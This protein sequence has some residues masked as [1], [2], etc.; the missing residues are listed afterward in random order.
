MSF[1]WS[2][3][4]PHDQAV[5]C[6]LRN[7]TT[8][9]I[10]LIEKKRGLGAGKVNAPGGKLEEGESFRAAAI[11]ETQEEVGMIPLDPEHYGTLRFAFTDGYNLEVGVF[12][13]TRWEGAPTETDEA[14]PFW[15]S[16]ADI[17]FERMWEDDAHWLPQVLAGRFVEAEMTF[18]GDVMVQWYI[19]FSHGVELIGTARHVFK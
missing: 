13:A 16:E 9:E 19:R 5:L 11:R 14:L 8:D 6:F 4:S 10:L 1:N 18:D 3:Y 12:I 15:V 2:E 7:F 17:P